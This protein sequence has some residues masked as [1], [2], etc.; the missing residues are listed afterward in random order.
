MHVHYTDSLRQ[1]SLGCC[2]T[3]VS[4]AKC[5]GLPG[6]LVVGQNCRQCTDTVSF[7][8]FMT[9]CLVLDVG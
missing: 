9:F 7:K 4:L 8:H 5:H 1:G 2:D 6:G 3:A